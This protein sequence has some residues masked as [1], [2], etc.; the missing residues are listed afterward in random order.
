[1]KLKK[2]NQE[3][4]IQR[5]KRIKKGNNT[6]KTENKNIQDNKAQKQQ[7]QNQ[8]QKKN[9]AD[10]KPTVAKTEPEPVIKKVKKAET[11]SNKRA[12]QVS[13]LDKKMLKTVANKTKK[14]KK[15]WYESEEVQYAGIGVACFLV[16]MV[17]YS[18]I[19]S[20]TT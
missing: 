18:Y 12:Y 4:K 6:K 19:F 13:T 15:Q 16:V 9:K 7:Q 17:V 20:S 2:I 3:Q 11:P 10:K 5:K 1:M 14:E 8:N